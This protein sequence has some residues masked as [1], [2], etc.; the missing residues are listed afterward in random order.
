MRGAALAALL[1]VGAADRAAAEKVVSVDLCPTY[2]PACANT[3]VQAGA[4]VGDACTAPCAANSDG[5]RWCPTT[6]DHS[7]NQGTPWGWCAQTA[8]AGGDDDDDGTGVGGGDGWMLVF[9][10]T[11]TVGLYAGGGTVWNHRTNGVI[12]HPH[13]TMWKQVGGLV[14]DGVQFTRAKTEGREYSGTAGGHDYDPLGNA[15][16]DDGAYPED[17]YEVAALEEDVEHGMTP[18]SSPKKKKTKKVKKKVKKKKAA[19]P[20]VDPSVEYE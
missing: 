19:A 4:A 14:V 12:R 9:A 10:I 13:I 18:P 11:L 16:E 6:A 1:L 15:V 7:G 3:W 20:E 8:P 17:G 2:V 5:T